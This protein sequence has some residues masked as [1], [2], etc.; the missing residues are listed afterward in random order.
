MNEGA[1]DPSPSKK[2]RCS[3]NT[4]KNVELILIA[5]KEVYNCQQV[6]K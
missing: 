2:H 4:P 5:F 1:F 6:V 3:A